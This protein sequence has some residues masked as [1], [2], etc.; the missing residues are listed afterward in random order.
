MLGVGG[1]WDCGGCVCVCVCVC[2]GASEKQVKKS[3][4]LLFEGIKEDAQRHLLVR[5]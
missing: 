1:G 2:V 3:I 4:H 5:V